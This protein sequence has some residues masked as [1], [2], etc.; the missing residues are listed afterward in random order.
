[1]TPVSPVLAAL[2]VLAHFLPGLTRPDLYFAVTVDP[3][4]RRT[5]AGRRIL[6]RYR[7]I[8]WAFVIAA[9]A[10]IPLIGQW[11][12][13]IELAG[14]ACSLADA[15]HRTLHYAE[16]GGTAIEVDLAAPEEHFPVGPLIVLLPLAILALLAL[17][18]SRHWG[19]LPQ[20]IPVHWGLHGAD[21]WITRTPAGIYWMLGVDAL[22]SIGLV[23]MAWGIFHWSKRASSGGARGAAER[24]YRRRSAQLLLLITFFPP[25]Q[26]AIALLQPKHPGLWIAL[27]SVP[28]VI[29]LVI[30]IRY[31]QG[32]GDRAP[33]SCWKLGAI[34]Y[35]PADPSIFIPKRFGIG[36]TVNFGNVRSW[37]LLALI[38]APAICLGFFIK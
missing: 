12:L 35:N 23:V 20:R 11:A 18:A 13:A 32:G 6:L 10:L 3:R 33:D 30:L 17:W 9:I 31:R 14:F 28:V 29:F 4:F 2:G 22:L 34:Y 1:M 5:D 16:P 27:G 19:Q 37:I 8:L 15:H 7:S 24:R 21:R 36:Y 26:A 38:L 25:A